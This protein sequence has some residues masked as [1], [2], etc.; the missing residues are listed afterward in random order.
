MTEKILDIY[1]HVNNKINNIQKER[2]YLS[3]SYESSY[4]EDKL[5]EIDEYINYYKQASYYIKDKDEIIDSILKN[6]SDMNKKNNDLYDIYL[7][8]NQIDLEQYNKNIREIMRNVRGRENSL[9][10]GLQKREKKDNKETE[11]NY[12]NDLVGELSQEYNLRILDIDKDYTTLSK[13]EPFKKEF[14]KIYTQE[15]DNYRD[16]LTKEKPSYDRIN[17]YKKRVSDEAHLKIETIAEKYKNEILQKNNESSENNINNLR[18]LNIK[19]IT[20]EMEQNNKRLNNIISNIDKPIINQDNIANNNLNLTKELAIVN[21]SN[22]AKELRDILD[23]NYKK[24]SETKNIL[25]LEKNKLEEEMNE[26]NKMNID[27]VNMQEINK[28]KETITNIDSSINDISLDIDDM[29][30]RIREVDEDEHRLVLYKQKQ[31][32]TKDRNMNKK[33]ENER[34]T[35]RDENIKGKRG[36]SKSRNPENVEVTKYN[37][38]KNLNVDKYSDEKYPHI[39]IDD[40]YALIREYINHEFETEDEFQL[41]YHE[42]DLKIAEKDWD[43]QLE[44]YT[45]KKSLEY[46]SYAEGF[47]YTFPPKK[48]LFVTMREY[49]TYLKDFFNQ[50]DS[51]K[52][53]ANYLNELFD[54]GLD[55]LDRE[56][57]IKMLK[58]KVKNR[59]K[60]KENIKNYY[61]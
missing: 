5:N 13:S 38:I 7:A 29:R 35:R 47:N 15:L 53:D 54:R 61:D 21:N 6:N 41:Y 43:A 14:E 25:L 42:L 51:T 32:F 50:Y 55:R 22:N 9:Q 39:N 49:N 48:Y 20:N 44:D 40:K 30:S 46:Y 45:R 12:V 24:Q 26:L 58:E 3:E 60:S 10:K 4:I 19:Q 23:K 56:N 34:K 17:E 52:E 11:L 57:Q 59:N 8:I 37:F 18:E 16:F 2:N 31:T 27:D 33:V 36:I 28:K 1:S